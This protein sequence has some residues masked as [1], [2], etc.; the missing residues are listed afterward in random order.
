MSIFRVSGTMTLHYQFDS[1]VEADSEDDISEWTVLDEDMS[2]G[3]YGEMLD[4]TF[5][6]DLVIEVIESEE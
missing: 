5:G 3:W 4:A 6:D 2:D 1:L